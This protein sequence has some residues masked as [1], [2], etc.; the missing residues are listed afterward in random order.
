MDGGRKNMKVLW[1][2]NLI[3][4]PVSVKLGKTAEVLGGWVESMAEQ[5]SKNS[6]IELAVVCK[7]EENLD[8]CETVNGVKYFS[9]YYT[10][11]TSLKELEEKCDKIVS[12]FKPDIINIEGTEY[13]T[14]NMRISADSFPLTI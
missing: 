8:F 5:L 6:D 9:L 11:S 14:G 12:D 10:S 3:P 13:S 4:A 2:V 7:C 1:T